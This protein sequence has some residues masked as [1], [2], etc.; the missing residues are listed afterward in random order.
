M[1]KNTLSYIKDYDKD[2]SI[3]E[4]WFSFIK[5]ENEISY[6]I[7]KSFRNMDI[8]NSSYIDMIAWNALQD[9]DIYAYISLSNTSL[10]EEDII[11][12]LWNL[13]YDMEFK[14]QT[15]DI[16]V[17]FTD[18]NNSVYGSNPCEELFLD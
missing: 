17:G 6:N 16:S 5:E 13:S 1:F 4:L 15:L 11:S 2:N 7:T 14:G 9:T 12:T 10:T 8:T 3:K 18:F